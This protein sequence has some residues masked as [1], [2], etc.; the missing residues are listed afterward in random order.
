MLLYAR[1]DEEVQP[2]GSYLMSGNRIGV[3][4]LD[5]E[6]EFSEIALQVDSMALSYL[7][8]HACNA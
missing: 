3:Q 2:E 4:T 6:R 1:T 8:G 5:L 7:V